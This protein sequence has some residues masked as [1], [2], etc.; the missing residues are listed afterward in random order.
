MNELI[1]VEDRSIG[2]DQVQTINARELH[3]FL[4]VSKDFSDW[5]KAQIERARIVE[6]RD[7]CVSEV[8]PPK[9]E[10]SKGG[11]PTKEYHL[12]LEAGKH[13]AMMSGSDKGFEV[14]EYFL[15][16]EKRSKAP[17]FS[18]P[19]FT[20]PAASARAWADQYDARK[21]IEARLEATKPAVE[22]VERYVEAGTS[23]CISD[24]AKIIGWNP[25]AYFAQL[26][27][28]GV[29]FKRGGIWLPHQEHIDAGRFEVKTGENE[30]FGF[31]QARVTQKGV[32]WMAEKYGT[33]SAA[34]LKKS[35][36]TSISK[37]N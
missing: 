4:E 29:I 16:C 7:Y 6:G 36:S 17:V 2:G 1:K 13:V 15:E 28:D 32:V 18:L 27:N 22:F 20:D 34:V 33:V 31:R 26:E 10:N 25:R 19:D 35:K 9:G 21:A 30:G 3:A 24:V 14:R 12:T 23:H 8:S 37:L 5:I 11:R